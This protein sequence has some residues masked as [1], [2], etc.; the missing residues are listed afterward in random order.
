MQGGGRRSTIAYGD[1]DHDVGRR[2]FRVFHKHVEIPVFVENP[3]IEQFIFPIV[4]PAPPVR[5]DQVA[6]GVCILR[7]FI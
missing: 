1:L 4:A 5:F 2:R 3:S 6:V 7:V